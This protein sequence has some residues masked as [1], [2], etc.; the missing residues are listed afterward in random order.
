[1]T[2]EHTGS[3]PIG[4]D[5]ETRRNDIL[6]AHALLVAAKTAL[7]TDSALDTHVYPSPDRAGFVVIHVDVLASML[8]EISKTVNDGRI[9]Q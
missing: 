2:V 6:R 5:A 7:I 4:P 8:G 1:M 3:I 9:F